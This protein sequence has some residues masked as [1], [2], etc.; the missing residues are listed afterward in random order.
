VSL[1]VQLSDLHLLGDREGQPALLDALVRA[2]DGERRRRERPADLL[3]VTGDV[4][5]SSSL[6]ADEAIAAF[7]DLHGRV[8]EALG[9]PDLPTVVVPGNHDRRRMG[10]F[11]PHDQ[12]LFDALAE[13]TVGE[14]FVHGSRVP[15][16]SEVVPPELHGLPL[17]LVVFDS[18]YL[19]HGWLSAGGALRQEDLLHAASVIG[20]REP[21]WPVVFLLH[22]HLVP[23]PLTDVG[24]ID[25][26][27]TSRLVRWGVEHLLPR[28]VANGDREELT[29]TA[30]GSGTALSTL[31]TMGRAVVVLHGHKH[32]ATARLLRGVEADQGDVMLVSA[33]SAGTAQ[34]WYPTTSREAARLWP[35]FNV[36]E[37][38][39]QGLAV[40]II[41]F[42]YDDS[43]GNVVVRPM[44]RAGREDARW[45]L[46]PVTGD[47]HKRGEA[48]PR[49]ASNELTCRLE[50][51]SS[52]P[53]GA[54]WDIVADRRFDGAPERTPAAFSDTVDALEDGTLTVLSG[55]KPEDVG[56][57]PGVV[58][59]GAGAPPRRRW[60]RRRRRG[61]AVFEVAHGGRARSGRALPLS[62][63]WWGLPDHGGGGPPLRRPAHPVR[64]ARVDEPLSLRPG[65]P[66]GPG[67]DGHAQGRLRER[68]GP[69][70]WPRASHLRDSWPHGRRTGRDRVGIRAVSAPDAPAGLLAPR[71]GAAP[72][73]GP[74]SA[75]P[76]GVVAG[77]LVTI[78]R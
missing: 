24:I 58:E 67:T 36:V 16:L 49:L 51:G 43:R 74:Y 72:L 48:G 2:L 3:V 32:Y 25:P 18:T 75:E 27:G 73:T 53:P 34:P 26:S 13:A 33:G 14:A 21:S 41:S 5:D 68:D 28:L 47:V 15:F 29:M 45:L 9:R 61:P 1:L 19:P 12:A 8:R 7:R 23:T 62:D 35:S 69:R 63:R 56:G 77:I 64:L 30:L 20:R 71:P 54:R 42:G 37:L 46:R 70:Q 60:R 55:P 52:G 31:H 38:G 66:G 10:I 22:H 65:P 11:G 44:V 17:W 59:W 57:R 78:D 50:P 6:P 39:D 76:R 4:F 40:D